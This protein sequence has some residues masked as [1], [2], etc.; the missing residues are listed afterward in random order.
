M[1]LF[2]GQRTYGVREGERIGE[3]P[4]GEVPLEALNAVLLPERPI[5]DLLVQRS[6]LICRDPWGPALAG[7]TFHLCQFTHVRPTPNLVEA[8]YY[9]EKGY[10]P[11]AAYWNMAYWPGS[12]A[13]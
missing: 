2:L 9:P 13:R 11:N 12:V 7:L 3:I 6:T 5:R 8:P 1:A 10:T 4:K